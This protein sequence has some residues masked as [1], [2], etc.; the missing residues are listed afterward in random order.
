[1]LGKGKSTAGK[2]LA[3]VGLW[4]FAAGFVFSEF[5][6]LEG[7]PALLQTLSIPVLILGMV[8][9]VSSNFFRIRH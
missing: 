2:V 7:T 9:V 8:M 5:V 1:M 3:Y 4:V 6:G